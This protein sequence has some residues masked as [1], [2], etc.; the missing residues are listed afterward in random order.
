[1]R[2]VVSTVSEIFGSFRFLDHPDS[3]LCTLDQTARCPVDH[4]LIRDDVDVNININIYR[5][6]H[7]MEW[8]KQRRLLS[9][10][11]VVRY[12]WKVCRG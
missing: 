12:L 10:V 8:Y 1:M 4:S 7:V 2:S 9:N 11:E 6:K 3:D 5:V